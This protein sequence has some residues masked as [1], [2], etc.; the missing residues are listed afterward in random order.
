VRYFGTLVPIERLIL[1]VVPIISFYFGYVSHVF[2]LIQGCSYP[3]A[4]FEIQTAYHKFLAHWCRGTSRAENEAYDTVGQFIEAEGIL[5]LT[6][7]DL[8]GPGEA[9]SSRTIAGVD[10]ETVIL[11]LKERVQWLEQRLF[12]KVHCIFH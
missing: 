4:L 8:N 6:G 9:S 2:V 1:P 10:A 7:M 11:S 12:E 3:W 5:Q